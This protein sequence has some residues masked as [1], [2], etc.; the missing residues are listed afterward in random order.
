MSAVVSKYRSFKARTN[1]NGMFVWVDH[2]PRRSLL[3]RLFKRVSDLF[4]RR[5]LAR[6]R[7]EIDARRIVERKRA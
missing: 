7:Q 4:Y 1:V 3:N 6:L 5:R 2:P